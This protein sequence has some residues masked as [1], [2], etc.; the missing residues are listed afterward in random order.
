MRIA[1]NNSG[2]G[3]R[4]LDLDLSKP[5]SP[6][7]FRDVLRALGQY[8]VLCFPQQD[9]DAAQLA[10]YGKRFGSLEVNVAN[11]F[12]APGFPEVMILS[13]KRDAEGKPIGLND[14]GQG[15]HTDMSYSHDIALAN[16]LHA[17]EVPLRDGRPLGDTQFRNQHA[18]YDDLPSEV[19]GRLEGKVAIH[20]FQKFWDMMRIRPGSIR[21]P[22]TEA[23]RAKKPPVRQPIFREHPITGRRV[24]YCNPGYAMIIEGMEKEESDAMLD[25]LFRHQSQAKYL[26]SHAWTPGDVLM[27]DNIGTT[28]NAMADYGPDEPR[29]ILRVQVMASLDYAALAA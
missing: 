9:L 8:G 13:N 10:D 2:L 1:P 27:W 4:I 25:Y 29:F 5:L 3:A 26:H 28:H 24:L 12:F 16:V 19:K 15:W 23:Q 18:A 17:K 20:D 6:A 21:P 11:M 14:A 22:L 7:D